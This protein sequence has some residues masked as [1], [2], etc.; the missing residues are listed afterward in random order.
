MSPRAIGTNKPRWNQTQENDVIIIPRRHSVGASV[1]SLMSYSE[2]FPVESRLSGIKTK[3]S[4]VNPQTR[5]IAVCCLVLHL[6]QALTD[7]ACTLGVHR[8]QEVYR[9]GV[10][11]GPGRTDSPKYFP[12]VTPALYLTHADC[13]CGLSWT[14]RTCRPHLT[15]GLWRDSWSTAGGGGEGCL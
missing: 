5:S 13:S 11:R 8:G 9:T 7:S 6:S 15:G 3:C 2:L 10:Q 4:L 1:I 12:S 14:S